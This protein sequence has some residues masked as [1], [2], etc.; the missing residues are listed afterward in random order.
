MGDAGDPPKPK[1][2]S[3]KKFQRP[4]RRPP[5]PTTRPPPPPVSSPPPTNQDLDGFVIGNPYAHWHDDDV[6]YANTGVGCDVGSE[7][8]SSPPADPPSY[9]SITKSSSPEIDSPKYANVAEKKSS[10]SKTPIPAG[11]ARRHSEQSFIKGVI[12]FCFGIIFGGVLFLGL[13]YGLLYSFFTSCIITGVATFGMALSLACTV[14]ARCVAALMAPTLCTSRGRAAFIAFTL[15]LLLNGPIAN[16]FHNSNVISE[17]MSCSAELLHEQGQQIQDAATQS[18]DNYVRNIQDSIKRLEE[19][20]ANVRKSLEPIE[21]GLERINHGFETASAV[22]SD[23]ADACT[24]IMEVA[25]NDCKVVLN[26]IYENCLKKL[27]KTKIP[28]DLCK[29]LDIDPLCEIITFG[30]KVCR[31]PEFGRAVIDEVGQAT[32]HIAEKIEEMFYTDIDFDVYWDS[33]R[34]SSR[35]AAGIASAIQSELEETFNLFDTAVLFTDRLLALSVV[36][37]LYRAYQYHKLYLTKDRFDNFYITK[38]FRKL[39][40]KRTDSGKESILPLKKIE[41]GKLIDLKTLALSK[42]ERG[43]FALGLVTILMYV[44]IAGLI[45]LVDYG[46]FWLLDIISRH[47]QVEYELTGEGTTEMDIGGTGMFSNFA[48]ALLGDGFQNNNEH[49]STSATNKCLPVPKRP[50]ERNNIIIGALYGVAILMVL[51]QAYALRLR[52]CIASFYYPERER[53]RINYLYS[54][55][56]KKRKTIRDMLQQLIKE[57]D[58]EQRAMEHI[59][60][61]SWLT[62]NNACC[63][64]IMCRKDRVCIGCA[65]EESE[66]KF[67][68]CETIDCKGMYCVECIKE[69][70]ELCTLC[71]EPLNYNLREIDAVQ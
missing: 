45:I 53:E 69:V 11:F 4:S 40:K 17:S 9:D 24:S 61:S 51:F 71:E 21:Y 30:N 50:D 22:L 8:Q 41:R 60:F 14:R 38:Q 23:A 57:N 7:C 44:L 36:Y 1:P 54:Q 15:T 59:S 3:I 10:I 12:G 25:Y 19:T 34:N 35:S 47:G 66:D 49:N 33:R 64:R 67:H 37:L 26:R 58:R 20:A 56:L 62:A 55:T 32:E 43:T 31:A 48:R 39:D 13:Y 52:R 16:I 65:S 27:S 68:Q 46:L 18:F 5:L 70:G 29:P 6:A 28:G 42:V 63:R 2:R